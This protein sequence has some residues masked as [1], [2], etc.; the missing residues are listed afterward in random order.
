MKNLVNFLDDYFEENDEHTLYNKKF[1]SKKISK[2]NDI[3]ECDCK[4]NKKSHKDK[5]KNKNK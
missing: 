4:N 3:D 5:H 1:N 2:Q